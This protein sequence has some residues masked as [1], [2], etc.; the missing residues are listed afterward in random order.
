[1]RDFLNKHLELIQAAVAA[2]AND[3]E[4]TEEE[5]EKSQIV[6]KNLSELAEEKTKV[7]RK[8]EIKYDGQ[9]I[10]NNCIMNEVAV[11]LLCHLQKIND[12]P[13]NAEQ[14]NKIA[15]VKCNSYRNYGILREKEKLDRLQGEDK[16]RRW[17]WDT[18]KAIEFNRT[19]YLVSN[20]W[21]IDGLNNFREILKQIYGE[22]I[23][24]IQVS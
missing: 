5:R 10:A 24:I 19:I 11:T 6:Q 20:Q 18:D 23:Q 16:Y 17:W 7:R 15:N 14:F 21:T 2:C 1:M 3:E 8:F 13:S 12:L 4:A 9:S 22:K